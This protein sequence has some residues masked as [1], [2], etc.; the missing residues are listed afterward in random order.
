M[1]KVQEYLFG[2]Y[3]LKDM[4]FAT[5]EEAK[6]ADAERNQKRVKSNKRI[7]KQDFNTKGYSV[8]KEYP[9]RIVKEK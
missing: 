3:D 5:L 9:T 4:A 7:R 2:W 1:Y 6:E 8:E